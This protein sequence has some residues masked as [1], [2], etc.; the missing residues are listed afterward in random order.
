M[1]GAKYYKM[2]KNMIKKWELQEKVRIA[3]TKW[4]LRDKMSELQKQNRHNCEKV[5]IAWKKWELQEKSENCEKK[6]WEL[7][8]KKLRIMRKN[9]E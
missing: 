7:R 8:E 1:K 5:R 9:S 2:Y 4:E 6:K 3:R